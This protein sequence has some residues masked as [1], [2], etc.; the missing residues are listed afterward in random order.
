MSAP[1]VA[2][3]FVVSLLACIGA[4][5]HFADGPDPTPEEIAAERE[6]WA[7]RERINLAAHAGR[8]DAALAACKAA[9]V[10]PEIIDPGSPYRRINRCGAIATRPE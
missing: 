3:A 7:E 9:G 1:T 5:A 8:Y 6:R 2:A 4:I 10:P